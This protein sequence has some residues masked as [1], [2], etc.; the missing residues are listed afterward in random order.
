MI[1][2]LGFV[3]FITYWLAKIFK[4][5]PSGIKLVLT[6]FLF[7]IGVGLLGLAESSYVS[8]YIETKGGLV[9]EDTWMLEYSDGMRIFIMSGVMSL[10]VLKSRLSKLKD[11][12][13]V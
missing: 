8:Y 13:V 12:G 6:Y 5:K 11:V 9:A 2:T 1:L 4:N 3:I 10:W 7:F